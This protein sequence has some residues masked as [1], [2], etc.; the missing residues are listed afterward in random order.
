MLRILPAEAGKK[1]TG[2]EL[3]IGG[4]RGCESVGFLEFDT[5]L[6][7]RVGGVAYLSKHRRWDVGF[8]FTAK[9]VERRAAVGRHSVVV[10]S[11]SESVSTAPA[12]VG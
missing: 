6:A 5:R 2:L 8:R 7:V 10:G 12:F 1:L 9:T 3:E 11:S 4:Q